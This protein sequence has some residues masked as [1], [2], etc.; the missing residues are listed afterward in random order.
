MSDQEPRDVH[1]VV[2]AMNVIG[3]RPDGWW[4]DREGAMRD[5]VA[6]LEAFAEAA[7]QPVTVVLEGR[8]FDV[9]LAREGGLRVTFASRRGPDAADDEIVA[10]VAGAADPS[11][12]L[13]VTSDAALA[14]R[15]RAAGAD[16]TPAGAFRRRLDRVA[17]ASGA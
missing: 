17:P 6:R 16:V 4:R 7:G 5:L 15:V 13:V 3:S 9:P 11:A 14:E 12:L 2:D 1:L 8:P 10:L